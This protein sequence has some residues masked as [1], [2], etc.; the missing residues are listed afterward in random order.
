[1]YNVSTRSRTALKIRAPFLFSLETLRFSTLKK[2]SATGKINMKTDAEAR[3]KHFER[4]LMLEK[5]RKGMDSAKK[6]EA[7]AIR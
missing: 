2:S 1:M 3:A 5:Y 7:T 6:R 4:R